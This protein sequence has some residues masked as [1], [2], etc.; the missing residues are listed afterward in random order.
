MVNKPGPWPRVGIQMVAA[1]AVD[2]TGTCCVT[3]G[4]NCRFPLCP[5]DRFVSVFQSPSGL[6]RKREPFSLSAHEALIAQE[7]IDAQTPVRVLNENR[8]ND[9]VL[10]L[11][12]L[13]SR[14]PRNKY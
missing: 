3:N 12:K 11:Q 10:H 2:L 7:V 8:S 6:R 9:R 4:T 5:Q 14:S 13:K 1:I